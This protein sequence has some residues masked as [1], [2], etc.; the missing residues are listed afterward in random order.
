MS[1]Q[2]KDARPEVA[3]D[4]DPEPRKDMKESWHRDGEV[5]GQPGGAGPKAE[6]QSRTS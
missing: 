2:D 6:K 4:D 5:P 3:R 1:H